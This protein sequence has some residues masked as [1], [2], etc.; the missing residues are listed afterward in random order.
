MYAV[1]VYSVFFCRNSLALCELVLCC[2]DD[3]ENELELLNSMF[4]REERKKATIY[5]QNNE[6]LDD[7]IIIHIFKKLSRK[8]NSLCVIFIDPKTWH[9]KK[10]LG[11][12]Y[13]DQKDT[14]PNNKKLIQSFIHL[15]EVQKCS[16]NTRIWKCG[17][18]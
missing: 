18:Q 5:A 4:G 14:L 10:K 3:W 16:K 11:S 9:T 15:C 8:R 1:W 2:A 6:R 7:V 13:F 12:F 17:E